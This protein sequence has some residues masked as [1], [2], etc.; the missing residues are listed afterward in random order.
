MLRQNNTYARTFQLLREWVREDDGVGLTRFQM[1]IHADRRPEGEHL[2]RYN[3]PESSEVAALIPGDQGD[4]ATRRDIVLRRRAERNPNVNKVLDKTSITH[5]SYDPLSYPL[6]LPWGS[7][8][9]FIERRR[10]AEANAKMTCLDYY[11]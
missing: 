2:R 3:A 11:A 10:R 5:R 8:E 6:L 1:V 9:W 7:D 4:R